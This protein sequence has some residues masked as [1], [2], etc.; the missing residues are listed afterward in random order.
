[1]YPSRMNSNA[2]HASLTW[3]CSSI[4]QGHSPYQLSIDGRPTIR[5]LQSTQRSFLFKDDDVVVWRKL[6]N[7]LAIPESEMP[8]H[9]LHSHLYT[10]ASWWNYDLLL[11]DI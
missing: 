4:S 9:I 8:L 7:V 3:R 10:K 11:R 2:V 1:M 6:G 5:Y